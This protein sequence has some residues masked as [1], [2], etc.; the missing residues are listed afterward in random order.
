MNNEKRIRDLMNPV[1]SYI[2]IAADTQFKHVVAAIKHCL[3]SR[4]KEPEPLN[5]TILVFDNGLLVGTI[6]IRDLLRAIEPQY[7]K[8]GNYRGWNIDSSW[9]IPVFWEGLFTERSLEAT[10]KKARDIMCTV[11]F[12]LDPDD[13]II[14][15]VY[16]CTKHQADA[17]PVMEGGLLTG[18]IDN[19]TIFNE[20]ASLVNP[21]G[22]YIID[23]ENFFK[24]KS[25]SQ[26]ERKAQNK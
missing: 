12:E 8:S 14:K 3:F 11:E 18:I 4:D 25:A 2:T 23:M 10:S 15:A 21:E 9:S 1:E 6:T 5:S 16:G 22:G 24:Y 19:T 20:L 17:L 7:L 13:P 26:P